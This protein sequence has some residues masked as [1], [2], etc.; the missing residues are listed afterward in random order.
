[1]ALVWA[2]TPDA[3]LVSTAPD[4]KCGDTEH[5]ML[6]WITL[7]RSW[8]LLARI[9][10]AT[11]TVAVATALQLPAGGDFQ[12]EPFLLYFVAVVASASVF[13][14]IARSSTRW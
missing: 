1:M 4:T 7:A 8:H 13:G 10:I 14:R 2:V 5:R 6:Q 12:G 3:R 11:I 9:G